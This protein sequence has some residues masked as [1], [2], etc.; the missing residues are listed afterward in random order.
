MLRLTVI[1]ERAARLH[2]GRHLV[3]ATALLSKHAQALRSTAPGEHVCNRHVAV[4]LVTIRGQFACNTC[5]GPAG[6]DSAVTVAEAAGR[7]RGSRH[8]LKV[9]KVREALS[10]V[11]ALLVVSVSVAV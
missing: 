1:G 9:K 2:G 7:W 3:W 8:F 11:L 6:P 5:T 10:V 4:Y